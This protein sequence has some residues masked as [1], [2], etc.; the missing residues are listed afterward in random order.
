MSKGSAPRNI[1]SNEFRNNYDDIDWS[2][3]DAN[4]LELNNSSTLTQGYSSIEGCIRQNTDN[5]TKQSEDQ[6]CANE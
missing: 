2:K 6:S 1:F 5:P 4:H 3:P